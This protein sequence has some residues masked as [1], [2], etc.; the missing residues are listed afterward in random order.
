[1][2]IDYT[3]STWVFRA[4]H[5]AIGKFEV[6]E[7]VLRNWIDR[8]NR[9]GPEWILRAAQVWTNMMKIE[10]R[11]AQKRCNRSRVGASNDC[12][13]AV[14]RS[15]T[16]SDVP[17]N[18]SAR[19]QHCHTDARRMDRPITLKSLAAGYRTTLGRRIDSQTAAR[20][21]SLRLRVGQLASAYFSQSFRKLFRKA[22]SVRRACL[23]QRDLGLRSCCGSHPE[24][25]GSKLS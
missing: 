4:S 20:D 7:Q 10:P 5:A 11:R 8:S 13:D 15:V 9:N 24:W 16:V 14:Y 2:L 22:S 6:V 19:N 25:V 21:S 1:M 18:H 23:L 17:R 3:D 12:C